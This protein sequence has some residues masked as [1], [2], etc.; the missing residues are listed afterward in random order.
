MT[1][2]VQIYFELSKRS[3][4]KNAIYAKILHKWQYVFGFITRY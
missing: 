4:N 2:K 1:A 3:A